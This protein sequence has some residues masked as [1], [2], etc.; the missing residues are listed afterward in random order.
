MTPLEF[1]AL[2]AICA[3]RIDDHA[4]RG[5]RAGSAGQREGTWSAFSLWSVSGRDQDGTPYR[6]AEY[7]G[8]FGADWREIAPPT[9][10]E[11]TSLPADWPLPADDYAHWLDA[12]VDIIMVN[13]SKHHSGTKADDTKPPTR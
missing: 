4:P 2:L 10:A 3:P 7:W 11:L 12:N 6:Y 13:M 5:D 8:R 9:T 1:L